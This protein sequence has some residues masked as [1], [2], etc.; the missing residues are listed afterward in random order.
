MNEAF[1]ELGGTKQ[2]EVQCGKV[3]MAS[4]GSEAEKDLEGRRREEREQ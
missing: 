4:G 3:S 2:T 1:C